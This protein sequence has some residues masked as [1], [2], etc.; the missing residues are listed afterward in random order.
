MSLLPCSTHIAVDA[1]SY[2]PSTLAMATSEMS[3]TYS[4]PISAGSNTIVYQIPSEL[5]PEVG[6]VYEITLSIALN[7]TWALA[8]TGTLLMTLG[9]YN[10]SISSYNRS[11]FSIGG[12]TATTYLN[13]NL[14]LVFQRRAS[15]DVIALALLHNSTLNTLNSV[16][17]NVRDYVIKK[18][19]SATN[20][21]VISSL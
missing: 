5:C 13:G 20:V 4:S 9:H 14:K 12:L 11:Q 2:T 10:S 7:P 16:I 18:I 21:T 19:A 15:D 3:M 17:I 1:P 8:P 6:A